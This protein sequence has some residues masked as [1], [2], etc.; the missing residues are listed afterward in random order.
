MFLSIKK[1]TRVLHLLLFQINKRK[2][3][4]FLNCL[5]NEN[6]SFYLT[7]CQK[8]WIRFQGCN[9]TDIIL[10]NQWMLTFITYYSIYI[11]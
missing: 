4:F 3:Y 2:A 1:K 8:V 11:K 5:N 7:F 10:Y 9:Y 6:S